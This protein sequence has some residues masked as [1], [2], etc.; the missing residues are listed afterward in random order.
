MDIPP[1]IGPLQIPEKIKYN[2]A[3][4]YRKNR[5]QRICIVGAPLLGLNTNKSRAT[6]NNTKSLV[7]LTIHVLPRN[8]KPEIH[9]SD[10]QND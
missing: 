4:N 10:Y 2:T 6:K 7:R 5:Q 9:L 1:W 3:N 8:C